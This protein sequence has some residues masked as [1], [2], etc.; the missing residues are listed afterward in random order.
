[1][2][3]KFEMEA[4]H[5]VPLLPLGGSQEMTRHS[6]P[7]RVD[8]DQGIAGM[9]TVMAAFVAGIAFGIFYKQD[10]SLALWVFAASLVFAFVAW[11]QW[12]LTSA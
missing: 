10:Y 12:R 2:Q 8:Q 6:S 7:G 5:A 1:M 11:S 4:G 9:L 3:A